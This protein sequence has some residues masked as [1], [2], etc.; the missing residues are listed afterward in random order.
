EPPPI[1]RERAQRA[2]ITV[3]GTVPDVRPF[4]GRKSVAVVPLRIA[5][6]IINKV[7]EPMALGVAVIASP[8]A[9]EGLDIDPREIC[10]VARTPDEFADGVAALRRDHD[11]YARLTRRAH[12]Y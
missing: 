9:V 5:S 2:G 3:T 8:A 1:L 11:L 6:G 4:F 10:I 7:I 12:E